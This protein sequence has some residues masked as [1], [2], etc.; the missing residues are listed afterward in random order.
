MKT[1]SLFLLIPLLLSGCD[2]TVVKEI[3]IEE[4]SENLNNPEYIIID[5]RP[6]SLYFGFKDKGAARGG[7]I[8]GAMQ[9]TT[10]WLDFI[11]EN[12]FDT[13]VEEKGISKEKPRYFTTVIRIHWNVLLPNL[14][15]K[16]FRSGHLNPLSSTAILICRWINTR[17]IF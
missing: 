8:K 4:L 5:T 10:G 7:H 17:I 15:P 16:V 6:D 1:K 11:D 13:F 3:G 9:F 2:Q 12:K 14:L